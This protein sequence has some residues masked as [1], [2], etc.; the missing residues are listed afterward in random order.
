[1]PAGAGLEGHFQ[2]GLLLNRKDNQIEVKLPGIARA[3][4][5][6][7]SF[8]VACRNPE[9]RQRLHLLIIGV[10]SETEEELKARA[11]QALRGEM[12]PG[13]KV[14]FKTPAFKSGI[15]HFTLCKDV[16][17]E[18][19][20]YQLEK[21]RLEIKPL[22]DA[23]RFPIGTEVVVIYYQ[24]GI[25]ID[26]G[27]AVLQLRRGVERNNKDVISFQELRNSFAG[28][29]GATLCL[30]DVNGDAQVATAAEPWTGEDSRTGLLSFMW[31][32]PPEGQAPEIPD[33]ARLAKVFGDAVQQTS[34]L[35][36]VVEE[37][38]RESSLIGR[39]YSNFRSYQNVPEILSGLVFGAP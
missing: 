18:R 3:A 38:R 34:T 25:W 1:M 15:L 21:I 4:G 27:K 20:L 2:A 12:L 26:D 35:G 37:S 14:A 19:V 13:S 9:Q 17:I 30:L 6:P 29:R 39:R 24:G 7:P 10:G 16:R 22:N 31:I 23:T 33:D 11:L 36:Q 32:K 8:S 28:T 5:D